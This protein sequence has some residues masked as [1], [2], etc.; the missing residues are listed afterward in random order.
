MISLVVY[1]IGFV[2]MYLITKQLRNNMRANKWEDVVLS[3]MLSLF[4]WIGIVVTLL[5]LLLS[6]ITGKLKNTKPPKW[7]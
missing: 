2:V 5:T 7:L 1:L 4:S 6:L 3:F